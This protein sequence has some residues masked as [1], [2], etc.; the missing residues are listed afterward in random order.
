MKINGILVSFVLVSL[1]SGCSAGIGAPS[2]ANE[3]LSGKDTPTAVSGDNAQDQTD[4]KTRIIDEIQSDYIM[5]TVLEL[6]GRTD[7]E[8]SHFF[9][10]GTENTSADGRHLIGRVYSISAFDE[11]TLLYTSYRDDGLVESVSFN[12]SKKTYEDYQALIS[13]HLGQPENGDMTPPEPDVLSTTWIVDGKLVVL[14]D[15]YGLIS[16][17]LIL[18]EEK[19]S[20]MPH[21]ID[22]LYF[23]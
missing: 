10:G 8:S 7:E 2:E 1:L 21:P 14:Y 23:P 12:L 6:L 4:D 11:P 18:P 17:Q 13:D 16:V 22:T 19:L 9:D 20:H 3:D 15:S 5:T